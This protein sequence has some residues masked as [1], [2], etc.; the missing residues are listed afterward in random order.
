[1]ADILELIVGDPP[2]RVDRL[3]LGEPL[4][5]DS[6]GLSYRLPIITAFIVSEV[7]SETLKGEEKVLKKA[8]R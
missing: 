3:R 6:S 5:K 8:L 7:L 2:C 1:M 4:W